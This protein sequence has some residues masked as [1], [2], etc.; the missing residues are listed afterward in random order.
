MYKIKVV[1]QD[2]RDILPT[3]SSIYPKKLDKE[4]IGKDTVLELDKKI[5]DR[6]KVIVFS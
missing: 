4:Q 1:Q 2:I 3:L 5:R 6:N